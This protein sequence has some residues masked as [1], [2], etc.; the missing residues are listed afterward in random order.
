VLISTRLIFHGNNLQP[1]A[2]N[3]SKSFTDSAEKFAGFNCQIIIDKAAFNSP[4]KNT[5]SEHAP[6]L[7]HVF[8]SFALKQKTNKTYCL[9]SV[10]GRINI[11]QGLALY[12]TKQ[13][14]IKPIGKY[15]QTTV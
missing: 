10:Y 8:G 1:S 5:S 9:N 7:E 13:Y 14:I 4:W 11:T 2:R 3:S 12:Q 15:I 6:S